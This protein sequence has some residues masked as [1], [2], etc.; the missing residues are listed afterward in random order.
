[1]NE[2][3]QGRKIAR[4]AQKWGWEEREKELIRETLEIGSSFLEHGAKKNKISIKIITR[5]PIEIEKEF[6]E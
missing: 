5:F 6:V 2:K 3:E 1:M 4:K